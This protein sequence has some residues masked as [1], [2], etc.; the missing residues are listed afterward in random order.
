MAKDNSTND[1]SESLRVELYTYTEVGEGFMNRKFTENEKSSLQAGRT[2]HWKKMDLGGEQKRDLNFKM[3]TFINSGGEMEKGV[4]VQM[5]ADKLEIPDKILNTKLNEEEIET[6]AKGDYFC[7]ERD[8]NKFLIKIDPNI[9]SVIVRVPAEVG[10]KEELGGYKFAKEELSRLANNQQVGP[11]VYHSEKYGYFVSNLQV[12]QEGYSSE[13]KYSNI[14]NISKKEAQK[15]KPLLNDHKG[16]WQENELNKIVDV[17]GVNGKITEPLLKDSIKKGSEKSQKSQ[18]KK[19]VKKGDN[20]VGVKL[21]KTIVPTQV[22][23]NN[24][25]LTKGKT[26]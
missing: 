19:R 10:I 8:Q 13:Y 18:T 24:L 1:R 11:K 17:M 12:S 7:L 9:N 16:V 5:K 3:Q 6:L 23:E 22:K 25:P 26:R 20:S 4:A 2:L 21:P 14:V 15:L